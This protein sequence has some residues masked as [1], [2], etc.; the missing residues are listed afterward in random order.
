MWLIIAG[1]FV[2][3][4]EITASRRPVS[5]RVCA[6]WSREAVSM[7]WSWRQPA[8][9]VQPR[10]QLSPVSTTWVDGWPVSITRQHGPSTRLVETRA[11][12]HGPCWRV[13]ETG[14]SS[15]RAV[16]SG[17]GNRALV[18]WWFIHVLA[19]RTQYDTLAVVGESIKTHLCSA[20][21]HGVM[22][23]WD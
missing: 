7:S 18:A 3:K 22:R 20:I 16:N 23:C 9:A 17:S 15:T 11:R 12:Q 14:R 2:H 1:V 8:V 5:G 10:G 6:G 13:M 4:E 19:S 21:C